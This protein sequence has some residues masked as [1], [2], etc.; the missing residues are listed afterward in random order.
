[1]KTNPMPAPQTAALALPVSF[2][3]STR[4]PHALL[5]LLALGAA[6]VTQP[7]KAQEATQPVTVQKV[8]DVSFRV[9]VHNPG[10]HPGRVEVQ[11]LATGQLLFSQ[12]Y[13]DKAYGHRFGFGNLAEG[14]YAIV[15]KTDKLQ[16]RY[17]VRL[18]RSGAQRAVAVRGIR[19]RLAKQSPG[20]LAA[21]PATRSAAGGL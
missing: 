11:N 16:Y 17:T 14:R 9:R 21:A 12:D 8:D 3:T 5:G 18:Q 15:V 6:F 19:V 4:L 2:A 13:A 1:M 7:A 20:S 10:L